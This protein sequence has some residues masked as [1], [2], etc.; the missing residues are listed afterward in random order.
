MQEDLLSFLQ[1]H[2]MYSNKNISENNTFFAILFV[3]FTVFYRNNRQITGFLSNFN[4]HGFYFKKNTITIEGKR[5]KSEF[6][7]FYTD[8]FSTR[9]KAL[10]EYI[11]ETEYKYINSI[12]EISTFDYDYNKD[13]DERATIETNVFVV[14]QN[15]KFKLA[16]EIYCKIDMYNDFEEK[17][18][19]KFE[20]E[21]ITIEIFSYK[22]SLTDIKNFIEEIKNNYEIKR[23][24]YRKNKKFIYMLNKQDYSTNSFKT[25][26]WKEYEFTSNRTFYNLFFNQKAELLNKLNFFNNNKAFYEKYGNS[27]TLGIALSGP[28]GTGKTSIIKSI[29]NLLKRHIIVIPLNKINNV[30]E[31][32]EIFF[33]STYTQD[34]QKNSIKFQDKIILIEDIDC[35]GDIVKKRNSETDSDSE[36]DI[37]K[38]SSKKIKNLIKNGSTQKTLTLSDI[39]NIIDGINETPG[40]ILI[41]S[42]N[43]YDKLDPALV[44]PGRIDHHIILE[45]A[46]GETIREI[47]YNYFNKLLSE[48]IKLKTNTYS[49]AQLINF[50]TFGESNYL[51]NVVQE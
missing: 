18:S 7:T 21:I 23:S 6:K 10:W 25:I 14:N 39:L 35:M 27:Y 36:S 45:N 13:S 42:S 20:T 40:R 38:V 30:E 5:L 16:D 46:S 32:Y 19:K 41:I 8:L 9:F 43:H 15:D 29:A 22:K 49:P 34:N 47:Y 37:E 33:E 28:P 44:R 17:D 3:L 2:M 31:L 12:K 51:K 50:A 24:D 1:L 4:L 26:T 11:G 48:K